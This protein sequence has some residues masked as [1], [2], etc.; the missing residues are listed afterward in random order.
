[1]K[2]DLSQTDEHV[3]C[4]HAEA[5]RSVRAERERELLE[6]KGPCSGAQGQACQLHYAHSGPCN[7][8]AMR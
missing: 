8:R 7:T 3:C 6:L 4:Y 1:M 2:T 5:A